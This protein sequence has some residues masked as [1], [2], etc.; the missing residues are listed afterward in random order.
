MASRENDASA[1]VC[2]GGD[3]VKVC[4]VQYRSL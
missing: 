1:R 4:E 2:A 3:T